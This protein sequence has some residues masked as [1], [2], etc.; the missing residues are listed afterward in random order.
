MWRFVGLANRRLGADRIKVF[1]LNDSRALLGSHRENHSH[2][3]EGHLGREGLKTLLA[4]PE[5]ADALG[6]LETPYGAD[7]ENIAAVRA[8]LEPGAGGPRPGAATTTRKGE[9]HG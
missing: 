9:Y 6:I 2:W 4:R 3:G 7:R 8:L 1:H 5:F